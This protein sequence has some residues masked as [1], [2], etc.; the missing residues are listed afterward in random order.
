MTINTCN[1]RLSPS[2]W[3]G[4]EVGGCWGLGGCSWEGWVEEGGGGGSGGG[5]LVVGQSV[6]IKTVVNS[7]KTV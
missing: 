6:G 1:N 3:S 4:E 5:V 2:L 7:F